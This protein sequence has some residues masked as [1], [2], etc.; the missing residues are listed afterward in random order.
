MQIPLKRYFKKTCDTVALYKKTAMKTRSL[1]LILLLAGISTLKTYG[2]KTPIQFNDEMVMITDSLYLKGTAWGAKVSEAIKGT[3][4]FSIL[5]P[6][7]VNMEN[8]I[9]MKIAKLNTMA[10]VA[11]SYQY[12]QAVI[13]YLR[14]EKQFAGSLIRAFESFNAQTDNQTLQDAITKLTNGAQKEKDQLAAVNVVQEAYAK[15]NNFTI[16]KAAE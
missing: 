9:N 2:Q 14:F 8:F 10:D 7:R 11:G 16:E 15:A 3:R 13:T 1:F 6:A 12:R 5:T 4:D